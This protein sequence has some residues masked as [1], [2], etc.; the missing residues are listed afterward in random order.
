MIKK[1]LWF[2]LSLV[3]DNWGYSTPLQKRFKIGDNVFISYINS[4]KSEE[5]FPL[6]TPVKIIET[7]RHDYLVENKE[8]KKQV[9]YQ[10]ELNKI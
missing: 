4:T 7:G 8:G 9:V 3:D 5:G 10:F 6:S 2:L 1:V